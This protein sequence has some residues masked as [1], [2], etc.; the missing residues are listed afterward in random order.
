[1]DD[2]STTAARLAY[3]TALA[4]TQTARLTLTVT[5]L[6]LGGAT[7]KAIIAAFDVETGRAGH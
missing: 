4:Q 3:R 6:T 7:V 5:V 2:D 1:V